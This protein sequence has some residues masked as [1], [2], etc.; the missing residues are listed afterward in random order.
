MLCSSFTFPTVVAPVD[1]RGN[2][3]RV[4]ENGAGESGLPIDSHNL[5]RARPSPGPL[6]GS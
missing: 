6:H 4:H 3:T 2:S 1:S 5:K